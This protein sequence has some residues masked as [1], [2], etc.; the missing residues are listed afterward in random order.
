MNCF[1]DAVVSSSTIPI[2]ICHKN[3][4]KCSSML[5]RVEFYFYC[6]LLALI[7]IAV[8]LLLP[9]FKLP[10]LSL[11]VQRSILMSYWH[12]SHNKLQQEG[13]TK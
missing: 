11:R 7:H 4:S 13:Q 5:V 2:L 8:N 1:V 12:I 6:S 10:S 3:Q 9:Q